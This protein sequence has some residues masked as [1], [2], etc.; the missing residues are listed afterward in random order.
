MKKL[1]LT[2]IILHEKMC[3]FH[4][5]Y[6]QNNDRENRE[7]VQLIQ[8]TQMDECFFFLK[9]LTTEGLI[10]IIILNLNNVLRNSNLH[11]N[12]CSADRS[13]CRKSIMKAIADT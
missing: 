6:I 9:D 2:H 1:Y 11:K 10:G 8:I 4:A 7:I 12:H 5:Y 3:P 13:S